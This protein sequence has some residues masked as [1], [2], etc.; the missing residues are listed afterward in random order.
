[1]KLSVF[2]GNFH[3][4]GLMKHRLDKSRNVHGVRKTDVVCK[5]F[6]HGNDSGIRITVRT[7]ARNG[8]YN[9]FGLKLTQKLCRCGRN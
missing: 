7:S 9:G 6:Q 3:V 1:M 8:Y 4:Y 2:S 5:F